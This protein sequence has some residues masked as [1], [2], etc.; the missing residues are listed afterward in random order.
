[1]ASWRRF[2]WVRVAVMVT[3]ALGLASCG[4]DG[5]GTV[6]CDPACGADQVCTSTG[7]CVD[8]V[9][10]A[11]CDPACGA[12]QACA[13]GA[14]VD[15]MTACE[16]ACE[17]DE[18]CAADGSCAAL[19]ITCEPACDAGQACAADGACVDLAVAC[20]P[21]C[22]DDQ[23]CAADG[24][25]VDLAL[26]CEPACGDE[27]ACTMDGA[28]V[29]LAIPCDPACA[30]GEVCTGDG[31][32]VAAM[33]PCDPACADGEV[34][35]G[36]G[37]CVA[38]MIPCDPA[39]ADGEACV[40]GVCVVEGMHTG[41]TKL[42][43]PFA[44]GPDVT[45]ACMECH[46]EAAADVV[47]SAHFQW[48]GET[49]GM[50]GH[51]TGAD[52]GK[53]NLINNFCIAIASNEPRCTQCHAGYGYADATFDFED[54][55]R[56]DCLVCHDNS[57]L[58]QKDMKTAGAVA[59]GVD[60]TVAAMSV[61][62]PKRSNCGACH[63]YAGGG[64]NVK[65]GD[66]GS[67]AA[68][69]SEDADVHMGGADGMDCVS[70]H[71]AEGHMIPGAGLHNPV[72][73]G[74]VAC[75]DCHQGPVVH[76]DGTLDQHIAH[77]ACETCHIPTFSRQQA[78]KLDWRWSVAGDQDREPVMDEYGKPDYDPK[79]GEFIWGM[80]VEP[81]LAWYNGTFTRMVVGDTYDAAPVD[82]GSPMGSIDDPDARIAP[83][84][85]F[86]G[87]QPAD[88][89]NMV[90]AVPHLF[91]TGSGDNPYW[92]TW[93]WELALQEGMA[94]A[95]VDYSGTFDFVETYLYM[96]LHHEVAPKE[97]ARGCMDCHGGAIDFTALG[98]TGDPMTVGG[99]HATQ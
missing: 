73:E 37:M 26:P 64:D 74:V 24:A 81:T 42:A 94:A 52:V 39:C 3:L 91:G 19:A 82:L 53:R 35:T 72:S 68:D 80:E 50:E 48:L 69:P 8:I 43:G 33:T 63:F 10:T 75:M 25:C 6:T 34:C 21:A 87:D 41:M 92:G 51:E 22:A 61:G 4:D 59:A 85:V 98:Y 29:D 5:G 7:A 70:C 16:P 57:G 1:M 65:K 31:M 14:C 40:H 95:G 76:D 84:K 2:A 36:D 44:E 23:A 38:A 58:Y 17:A 88:T 66:L 71:A 56:V 86:T 18:V 83:F 20:D 60:L 89:V 55:T 15:L 11:T 78:T 49:P 30:D 62:R 79:K 93:D 27:Q 12:G 67:W 77:V 32:C 47:G 28:C 96:E 9:R 46:S 45:A 99:E 54:P 97:Q 90:I 13:D